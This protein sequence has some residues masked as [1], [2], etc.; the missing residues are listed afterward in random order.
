MSQI[1]QIIFVEKNCHVEKFWEILE[2]FWD[3]L[4]HFATI[5]AIHVEKNWAQ[6][7]H[8][9]RKMTNI[10][11]VKN[12]SW[13]YHLSIYLLSAAR[14]YPLYLLSGVRWMVLFLLRQHL[15]I[16]THLVLEKSSKKSFWYL[17]NQ[18]PSSPYRQ[19]KQLGQVYFAWL[20]K[21]VV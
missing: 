15:L 11:S 7:V 8:L 5:Y 21:W 4:G 9:W 16:F 19:E 20:I 17:L 2:K 18:P 12:I 3:I 13:R 6:K 1:S 14:F 10:R